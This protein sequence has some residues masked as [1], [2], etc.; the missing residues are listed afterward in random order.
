VIHGAATQNNEIKFQLHAMKQQ[1]QLRDG[2]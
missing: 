1:A 2:E